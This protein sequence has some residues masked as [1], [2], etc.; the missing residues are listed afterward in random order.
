MRGSNLKRNL[1]L[2]AS[3]YFLQGFVTWYAIEKLFFRADVGLSYQQIGYV[4]VAATASILLFEFPSGI[5]ADRWSRKGTLI[6]GSIFLSISAVLFALGDS[7]FVMLL[8]TIFWGFYFASQSGTGEA[9]LYDTL[10]QSGEESKF[11]HYL[12]PVLRTQGVAIAISSIV[13]GIIASK[14]GFRLNYWM[15]I[16]PMLLSILFYLKVKEPEQHFL[17]SNPLQHAKQALKNSFSSRTLIYLSLSM[18]VFAIM[19]HLIYE[20]SQLYFIAVNL[21]TELFGIANALLTISF[22]IGAFGAVAIRK[23]NKSSVYISA[24]L[25]F[26]VSQLAMY[27]VRN[28]WAIAVMFIGAVLIQT[29]DTFA[30]REIQDRIPSSERAATTSLLGSIGRAAA[31]PLSVLVG[32]LTDKYDFFATVPIY[33]FFAMLLAAILVV[34]TFRRHNQEPKL[35]AKDSLPW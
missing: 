8:G 3:G 26:V 33:V 4:G 11:E 15:T 19:F 2:I 1:T 16:I 18:V 10:K 6:L 17:E 28:N 7:F 31:I 13:G 23:I 14:Y 35:V 20:F 9:L 29:L 12:A 21:P 34:V 22:T 25:L 27:F 5:L 32:Y 30:Q 24:A